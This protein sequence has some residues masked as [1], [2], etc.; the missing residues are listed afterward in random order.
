M[1]SRDAQWII[2]TIVAAVIALSVQPVGARS[3]HAEIRAD[4]REMR[5]DM[6]CLDDRLRTVEVAFGKVDRRLATLER[7]LFPRQ[8]DLPTEPGRQPGN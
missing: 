2:G 6:R 1:P 8:V 3:D 5:A 4:M 7:V